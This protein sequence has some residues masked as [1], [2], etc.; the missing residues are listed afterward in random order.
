MC[1]FIVILA[2]DLKDI[3]LS[4]I[5][6]DRTWTC[7]PQEVLER[8]A[9]WRDLSRKRLCF[10]QWV[11]T[12][13]FKKLERVADFKWKVMKV[14]AHYAPSTASFNRK[15][16]GWNGGFGR[17]DCGVSYFSREKQAFIWVCLR[18]QETKRAECFMKKVTCIVRDRL[19]FPPIF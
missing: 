6:V 4:P 7:L 18:L 1:C 13:L 2:K 19:R 8:N 14:N 17:G 16:G 10:T 15:D 12:T 9:D 5:Q 3:R 11:F